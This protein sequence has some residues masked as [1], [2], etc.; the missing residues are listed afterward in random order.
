MT[1]WQPDD[2]G[3]FARTCASCGRPTRVRERFCARHQP[4]PDPWWAHVLRLV[5]RRSLLSRT[6]RRVKRA[7][8][9][10]DAWLGGEP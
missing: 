3:A 5:E 7:L 8:A 10:L 1:E 2:P 4:D 6:L 9:S